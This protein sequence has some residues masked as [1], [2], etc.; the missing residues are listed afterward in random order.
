MICGGLLV[1]IAMGIRHGFGFWQLPLTQTHGWSRET[2]TFAI[3]LQNLVWGLG[4]PFAGMMADKYGSPRV[5]IGGAA[6]YALGLL[7]MGLSSSGLMFSTGAGL[8]IGLGLS[9]A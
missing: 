1:S 3:A 8:L 9:G 7:V 6:L 4:Q 2:F 5:A